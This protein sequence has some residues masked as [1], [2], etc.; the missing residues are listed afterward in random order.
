MTTIPTLGPHLL[1]HPTAQISPL[2]C[3]RVYPNPPP[4]SISSSLLPINPSHSSFPH[5]FSQRS[6]YCSLSPSPSPSKFS[7]ILTR[8]RGFRRRLLP[9][10]RAS[11]PLPS[12]RFSHK[13]KKIKNFSEDCV[14]SLS[15][16][17]LGFAVLPRVLL[18]P[19]TRGGGRETKQKKKRIKG[20]N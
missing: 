5:S 7:F 2:D 4:S 8:R 13:T 19:I 11:I 20:K 10:H 16:T 9:I 1:P 15:F 3:A 14:L 18:C 12:P 17:E 6:I